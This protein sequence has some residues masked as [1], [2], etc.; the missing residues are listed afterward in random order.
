MKAIAYVIAFLL[1][2]LTCGSYNLQVDASLQCRRAPVQRVFDGS[3]YRPLR[4]GDKGFKP[5][6]CNARRQN[7]DREQSTKVAVVNLTMVVP[8]MPVFPLPAR[9]AGLSPHC[10]VGADLTE[11]GDAP[12]PPPPQSA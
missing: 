6:D 9:I 1:V 3:A 4:P 10:T 2:C 8:A 12:L 11:P 7:D 5:C